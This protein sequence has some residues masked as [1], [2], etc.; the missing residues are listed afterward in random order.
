[1]G[2]RRLTMDNRLQTLAG[3]VDSCLFLVVS[4]LCIGFLKENSEYKF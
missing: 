3:R 4:W 2:Q 1:M